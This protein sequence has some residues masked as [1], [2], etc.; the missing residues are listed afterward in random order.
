LKSLGDE[1]RIRKTQEFEDISIAYKTLVDPEKRKHYDITGSDGSSGSGN[2]GRS[3]VTDKGPKGEDMTMWLIIISVLAC[4]GVPLF[5]KEKKGKQGSKSPR[6]GKKE[7]AYIAWFKNLETL[8]QVYLVVV[9][10]VVLAMIFSG[11]GDAPVEFTK[12]EES[13]YKMVDSGVNFLDNDKNNY[14][15]MKAFEMAIDSD[16]THPLPYLL[17]GQAAH[18]AEEAG[19][20]KEFIAKG[21][22]AIMTQV[23]SSAS[24]AAGT[25]AFMV[26]AFNKLYDQSD[27]QDLANSKVLK[28]Q[29]LAV[30]DAAEKKWV[31][32]CAHFGK[33]LNSLRKSMGVD[34]ADAEVAAA[35][36]VDSSEEDEDDE[37]FDYKPDM[38][39]ML[40]EDDEA[41]DKEE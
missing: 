5:G 17:S 28:P 2:G 23:G 10:V 35:G 40:D 19:E 41:E 7:N 27:D 29:A 24:D 12:D 15:A 4:A 37:D 1:E 3:R 22:N 34:M 25:E 11:G 13:F 16:P 36:N 21:I 18:E 38:S 14:K 20:A 33:K 6:K 31:R 39:A 26:H 30:I 8:Q 32:K 9:T